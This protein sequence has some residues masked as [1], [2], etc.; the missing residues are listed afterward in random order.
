MR[1]FQE[2][3]LGLGPACPRYPV[4][5]WGIRGGVQYVGM[6]LPY[7]KNC[8]YISLGLSIF[9]RMMSLIQQPVDIREELR[10]RPV[11]GAREKYEW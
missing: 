10:G 4:A 6:G 8:A 3:A 1:S 2:A 9:Y 5:L 7:L 11:T